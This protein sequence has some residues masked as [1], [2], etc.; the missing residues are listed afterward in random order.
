M[1]KYPAMAVVEF[2]EIG[3]GMFATDKMLKKAPIAF[4]RCGTI[5][6][7]R[8]LTA[9]G[10]STASVG[11]SFDEGLFWGGDAVLDSVLLADVHPQVHDAILGQH[12]PQGRGALAIVETQTVACNVRAAELALKGTP[13]N[14]MELRLADA[15]L[16]GKGLSIYEGELYD[17]EAAMDIV[18]GFLE[19]AGK[20][21]NYQIISSPHE[22]LDTRITSHSLFGTARMI[23]LE[24]ESG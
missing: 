17:I 2:G 22:A 23:E 16:S 15:G 11:E 8:Y 5:S 10:G 20:E 12:R 14:L 6:R 1:K 13:V 4:I 24:G 3:K 9:I 21:L 19:A 7:G 18:S